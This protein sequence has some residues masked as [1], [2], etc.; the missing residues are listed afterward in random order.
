MTMLADQ[1]EVVIGVDTHK[2]THSAAVVAAGTG[3][4]VAEATTGAG[5]D[6]YLALLDLAEAHGT[7]RVWAIEGTGGYGAG[8]ARFLIEAGEWVVELER[9]ERAR[10]KGGAKSDSLDAVRAA[11]EALGRQ[12]LAEPRARGER[13][14][15]SVLLAARRSA[16][17]AATTAQRQLHALV[18][19]APE[20][21]R[22]RFRGKTTPQMVAVAA[23]L[24]ISSHWNLETS[25]T[26]G[27]LRSLAR[28]AQA[29]TDEADG[30]EAAILAVVRCWRPDLLGEL[31]VGPIVAAAVLC[32]WSHPGRCRNDGAFAMLAGTAPIPASSGLTTR[33]R[34]NRS[35]DRQLNR[36][37]HTVVLSRLRYDPATKAYAER[38]T[39]E[40]KS[41]REIKR[42][43]KRYVARQIYRQLENP[44]LDN[45]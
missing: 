14:A 23:R 2:H 40:G 21:L 15:L 24:R 34:L 19:A 12:Q 27:V 31:G 7:L 35:G 9:P 13:A 37:L 39:K 20:V 1:V 22:A 45:P 18:V 25:T 43:L 36:A 29:M 17:E 8:L 28:R 38:R 30:H 5:P 10:R 11:R 41:P 6:G 44:P 26:A 42:C 3:A 16:V 33:H 32:A 4:V